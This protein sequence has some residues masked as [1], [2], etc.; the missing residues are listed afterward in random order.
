MITS[1]PWGEYTL[2]TLD[3]GTIQAEIADLGATIV[4][5]LIHI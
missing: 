5:S 4:L 2:F 1:K 3:N